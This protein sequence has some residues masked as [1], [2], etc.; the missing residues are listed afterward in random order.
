MRMSK[1]R[2]MPA[3]GNGS[4]RVGWDGR[5]IARGQHCRGDGRLSPQKRHGLG[6][7]ELDELE[8][9]V[10][11]GLGWNAPLEDGT[12]PSGR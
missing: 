7:V 1:G 2:C 4:V 5:P 9:A 3:S 8:A 11:E 6:R 10:L 12:R